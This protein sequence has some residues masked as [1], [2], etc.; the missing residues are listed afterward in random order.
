MNLG[1]AERIILRVH[2][3]GALFVHKGKVFVKILRRNDIPKQDAS[4][5]A[6][7]QVRYH[8]NHTPTYSVIL[9]WSRNSI[10]KRNYNFRLKIM[11]WRMRNRSK[12]VEG[13]I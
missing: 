1:F 13:E 6:Q 9:R 4:L 12:T 8:Q 2:Y 10:H 3:L 5:K 7:P 11:N